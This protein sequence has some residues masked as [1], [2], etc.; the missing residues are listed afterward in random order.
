[1]FPVA[2]IVPIRLE[3]ESED[4]PHYEGLWSEERIV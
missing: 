4:A 2:A 1:M 3:E